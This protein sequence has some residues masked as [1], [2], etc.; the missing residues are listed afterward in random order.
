MFINII[1][2][3]KHNRIYENKYIQFANLKS[4][5][6]KIKS[7]KKNTILVFFLFFIYIYF[8]S[9]YITYIYILYFIFEFILEIKFK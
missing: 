6:S 8:L 1:S 5:F 2:K 3:I 4:Q 7:R 9:S